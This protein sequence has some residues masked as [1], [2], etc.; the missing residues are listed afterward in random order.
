EV[1]AGEP[2]TPAADVY[3]VAALLYRAFTGAPPPLEGPVDLLAAR[4][5]LPPALAR[6][7]EGALD[8]KPAKR[9]QSAGELRRPL[10]TA[11]IG[12]AGLRTLLVIPGEAPAGHVAP[13]PQEDEPISQALSL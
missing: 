2:A 10:T 12:A 13:T 1:R 3:G 8:P 4:G 7:V 6:A 11:I 9:P 5:E